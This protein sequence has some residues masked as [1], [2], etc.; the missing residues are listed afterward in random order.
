MMVEPGMDALL[1]KVDSKYTLVSVSSKRA[2]KVMEIN[3][4]IR[5]NPVTMALWDIA[6]GKV[7]WN[8][9][10]AL[11]E[12]IIDRKSIPSFAVAG[13]VVEGLAVEEDD[14]EENSKE[15]EGDEE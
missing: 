14:E 5:E 13:D 2:R 11:E 8:R 7:S 1:E 3:E 4:D 9:D 12:N 15:A 6:D 10:E